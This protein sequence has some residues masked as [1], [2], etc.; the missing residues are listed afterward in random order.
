MRSLL[1]AALLALLPWRLRRLV[2]VH[3]LG[4]DIAP[5]A[6][7]GLSLVSVGQ[8]TMGEGARIGHLTMI[9]GLARLSMG[10]NGIVGNLNW[11]SGFS[12]GHPTHFADDTG[13]DP[14]LVLGREA[15]I[16]NRHLI[17]CTDRVSIGH[18]STLAGFRTQILTHS[19][20]IGRSVQRA[21]PVTIGAYCFVGTA[22]VVLAG[23]VL[24]DC[25]VLGAGSVLNK[26]H[27]ESYQLYAGTPA[28]PVKAMPRDATYFHRAAGY[29][30]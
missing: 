13:R 23:S 17:D 2:M 9:K 30:L 16:T 15:A 4:H 14:S 11:I 28:T 25:S 20:D 5:S 10:E 1:T 7:I 3:A 12:A 27:A 18:H 19:I 6:R 24:P 29:V 22:C 21:Q 26:A 8:L